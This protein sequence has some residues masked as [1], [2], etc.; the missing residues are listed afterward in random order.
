[1]TV[2][3]EAAPGFEILRCNHSLTPF[4]SPFG[5]CTVWFCRAFRW[6]VEAV[7]CSAEPGTVSTDLGAPP[8]CGHRTPL[9]RPILAAVEHDPLAVAARL[10]SL[11]RGVGGRLEDREHH[12]PDEPRDRIL[13]GIDSGAESGRGGGGDEADVADQFSE[14]GRCVEVG[15]AV[16]VRCRDATNRCSDPDAAFESACRRSEGF[17]TLF[18]Q[19]SREV[20]GCTQAVGAGLGV[21]RVAEPA[22]GLQRTRSVPIGRPVAPGQHA[23]LGIEWMAG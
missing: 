15:L 23:T 19:P 13:S 22:H 5:V 1:M 12:R 10:E 17:M 3:P 7:G 8:T 6:S 20:V 11:P 16:S 4:G 9:G 14:F 18:V 2:P 21:R